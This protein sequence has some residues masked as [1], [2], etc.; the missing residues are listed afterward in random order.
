[1]AVVTRAAV[2]FL[3][4]VLVILALSVVGWEPR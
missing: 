1:M 4:V 2:R 3:G